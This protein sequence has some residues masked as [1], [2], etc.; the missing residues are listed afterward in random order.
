MQAGHVED[1]LARLKTVI[2]PEKIDY[3]V[4]NHLEPDHA[5]ALPELV[6]LCKP[7]KIFCSVMAAQTMKAYFDASSWPIQSVKTGDV[8]NIGARNIH[9][10]ETRMLHWPDSMLSYIPEEKL[11]I[12]NDAFGQPILQ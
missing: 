7:E 6:K 4:V 12:S 1:M 9:F 11:L 2:E 5:G 10:V 3:I 8:I